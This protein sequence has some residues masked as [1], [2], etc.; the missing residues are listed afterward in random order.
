VDKNSYIEFNDK[1]IYDARSGKYEAFETLIKLCTPYISAKAKKYM[2]YG[3]DYDDLCQEG[4]LGLMGA[5]RNYDP[6]KDA[7]FKTFSLI[8]INRKMISA[9][10]MQSRKKRIKYDNFISFDDVSVQ[11]NT[12][13][14]EK[15]SGPEDI[16]IQRE[17]LFMLK[18]QIRDLLSHFEYNAL[19]LYIRG[20]SYQESA[21]LLG[22]T[23]KAVDNALQR[24]RRKLKSVLKDLQS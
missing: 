12:L 17:G 23:P 7:S 19:I 13:I 16:M 11:E 10:E 9:L 21:V 24:A 14:A 5:I 6:N 2:G 15:Q 20:C 8:C 4:M 1:I 18:K 3:I 22:I